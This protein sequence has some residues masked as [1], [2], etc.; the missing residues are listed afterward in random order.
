MNVFARTFTALGGSG[1]EAA[2][3]RGLA[4][5]MDGSDG[6]LEPLVCGEGNSMV[7]CTKYKQRL[8]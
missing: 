2:S 6:L 3:F 7:A 1:A 8:Y 4:N 5:S